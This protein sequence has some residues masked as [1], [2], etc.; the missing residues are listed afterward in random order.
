MSSWAT[1]DAHF[2]VGAG[3]DEQIVRE[4]LPTG[5]ESGPDVYVGM[6]GWRAKGRLRDVDD[7]DSPA[8][9]A[10]FLRVA[11]W[12]DRA[13]LVWDVDDGPRY[14]YVWRDGELTK[15]RGILD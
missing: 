10:W 7:N 4:D 14:R 11:Q 1:L 5:S 15:L 9:L 13:E 3:L 8:I 12:S 6:T 2:E